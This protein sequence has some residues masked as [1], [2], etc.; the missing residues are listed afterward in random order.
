MHSASKGRCADKL[1]ASVTNLIL[2]AF[3]M[4]QFSDGDKAALCRVTLSLRLAGHH[5]A[6]TGITP[7]P[8]CPPPTPNPTWALE[9]M[10]HQTHIVP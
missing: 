5:T 7:P 3:T 4:S 6:G 9:M 10:L 1:I 2:N 8:A